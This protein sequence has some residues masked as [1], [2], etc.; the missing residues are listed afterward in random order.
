MADY[1][2]FPVVSPFRD[3]Q[4]VIVKNIRRRQLNFLFNNNTDIIDIDIDIF[5]P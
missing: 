1:Y 2:Y 5:E 4:Q 3:Q